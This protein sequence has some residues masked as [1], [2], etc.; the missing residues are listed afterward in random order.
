MDIDIFGILLDSIYLLAAVFFAI[1]LLLTA[2]SGK[3][4]PVRIFLWILTALFTLLIG[5][6]FLFT[7]FI[8]F[9]LFQIVALILIWDMCVVAGAVCGGGLYALRH[10]RAAHTLTA[11]DL[12]EFVPLED[13]CT[14]EGVDAERVRARISSGYYRGGAFDGKWYVHR[15]EQSR[16]DVP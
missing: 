12:A 8:I 16:Q 13:F 6:G 15:S 7:P 9:L 10:K 14:H 4:R 2:T 11:A 3:A 1:G 5:V